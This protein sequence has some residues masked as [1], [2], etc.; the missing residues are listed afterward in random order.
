MS[1][2]LIFLDID[3]TL[4]AALASPAPRIKQAIRQARA[5]GHMAFL[6]TGRNLPIIGQDILEI[7]FDGIIASAGGYVSVGG[8]VLFDSLLPEKLVQECL[9]VFHDH[10]IFCRIETPDGIYTDPQME[11]LLRNASAD[12]QNSELIRMQKEIEAGI[13]IQKY[14]NY[15]QNGAYKLCFTSTDLDSVREVRK[16]LGDRFE[17]VVHPYGN[18]SACFNGEIIRKGIDKGCAMELIC[19]HL[20]AR[21]EDTVAFGDSMNDAAMLERAGRGVAMGNACDELKSLADAVC[22]DVSHDG[23]YHE[24][25]RMGLC[26]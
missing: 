21:I 16:H 18:S 2:K 12:P 23:V 6:C 19:R 10:G 26:G 1:K 13:A 5:R 3:G 7:G 9:A 24:F 25:Y 11:E 20:N 4:V 17:F 22:E 15:P 8:K 14:E